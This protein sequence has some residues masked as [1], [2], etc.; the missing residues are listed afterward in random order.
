[1]R[2]QEGQA[3]KISRNQMWRAG[4]GMLSSLLFDHVRESDVKKFAEAVNRNWGVTLTE[5]IF[6]GQWTMHRPRATEEGK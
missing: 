3:I 2:L 5:D 4:E 1:M 6:T